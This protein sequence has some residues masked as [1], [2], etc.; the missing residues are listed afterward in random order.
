MLK[1]LMRLTGRAMTRAML[2]EAAWNYQSDPQTN[3]IHVHVSRLR[4]KV[5]KP[6]PTWL[7]QTV[8]GVGFALRANM[9]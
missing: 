8:C 9:V 3:V 4:W 1:Y 6:F 7:I 5:D 2:L